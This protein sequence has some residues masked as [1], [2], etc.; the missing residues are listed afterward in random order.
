[1]QARLFDAIIEANHQALAGNS[2]ACVHRHEFADVLPIAALTCIDPRLNRFFPGVLGIGEADFIWLRNAG[3]IIFDPLSS[4]TRSIALACAIKGAREI[5][6]IGHS[7][8]RVGKMTVGELTDRFRRLGIERSQLPEDLT[9]YFGMFA[10]E[11]QNVIKGTD[12]LRRSPLIGKRIPIHG[13]MVDVNSGRLDWVVN[14]Y[15]TFSATAPPPPPSA[16]SLNETSEFRRDWPAFSLIGVELPK[17]QIG[18]FERS[19]LNLGG[20]P[21]MA[22]SS[23][24]AAAP[25][26]ARSPDLPAPPPPPPPAATPLAEPPRARRIPPVIPGRKAPTQW[27]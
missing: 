8:C 2:G 4:M 1:M 27:R 22:E 16:L 25:G 21:N 20:P 9:E 15:D 12:F 3:N 14:G 19:P 24:P 11:S 17:T 5:A 10:S 6:V 13:L 23:S 18:E 26:S 7:D